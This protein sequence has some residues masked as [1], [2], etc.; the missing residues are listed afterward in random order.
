MDRTNNEHQQRIPYFWILTA[1]IGGVVI[2]LTSNRPS[3]T[4][5]ANQ[6]T[7]TRDLVLNELRDAITKEYGFLNGGPKINQGPCVAFAIAFQEEWNRRFPEPVS[8]GIVM[9]PQRTK[10]FHTLIRLPDGFA[11]DGGNGVMPPV[12]LNAHL[13]GDVL[14]EMKSPDRPW[15]EKNFG[16]LDRTYPRCPNYDDRKTRSIIADHLDRLIPLRKSIESTRIVFHAAM[17]D[18]RPAS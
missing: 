18:R 14:V 16:K 8:L 1:L 10:A 2:G 9:D 13:M 15:L 11:F 17:P 7:L 6:P 12:M 5:P 3:A 4:D